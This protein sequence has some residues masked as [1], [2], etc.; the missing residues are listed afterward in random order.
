MVRRSNVRNASIVFPHTDAIE[1]P[2]SVRQKSN[3]LFPPAQLTESDLA[4][5]TKRSQIPLMDNAS[6]ESNKTLAE[7]GDDKN[8]N[9]ESTN[10]IAFSRSR[11]S[12]SVRKLFLLVC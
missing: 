12:G 7:D 10:K 6:N 2:A 8:N 5:S 11:L 1:S 9:G 3:A 4:S